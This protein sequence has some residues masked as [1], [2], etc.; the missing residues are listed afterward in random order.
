MYLDLRI[1][2]WKIYKYSNHIFY[3]IFFDSG[4]TASIFYQRNGNGLCSTIYLNQTMT[5]FDIAMYNV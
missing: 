5:A 1:K 4:V 3:E 2:V